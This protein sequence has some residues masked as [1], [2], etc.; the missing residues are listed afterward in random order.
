MTVD[1]VPNVRSC[2]QPLSQGMQIEHQNAW[3]SLEHD[4]FG[5]ID[6]LGKINQVAFKNKTLKTGTKPKMA[7]C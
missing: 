3:P 7:G 4:I 2:T 1:G 5:I 6:R